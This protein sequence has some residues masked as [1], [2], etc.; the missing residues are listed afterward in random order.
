MVVVMFHHLNNLLWHFNVKFWKKTSFNLLLECV[1]M[2][3]GQ[4]INTPNFKL[5][6]FHPLGN[7]FHLIEFHDPKWYTST[8]DNFF[9]KRYWVTK[10]IFISWWNFNLLFILLINI[11]IVLVKKSL[12]NPITL[13]WKYI[14]HKYIDNIFLLY[15][16]C[17]TTSEDDA[18]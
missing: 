15:T 2:F 5:V 9:T 10:H 13:D 8:Y 18:L 12:E 11:D 16:Y 17:W 6:S 14:C 7:I 3:Q 1:V 4:K